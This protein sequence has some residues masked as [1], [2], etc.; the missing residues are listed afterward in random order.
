[1]PW[2][3]VYPREN[4]FHATSLKSNPVEIIEKSLFMSVPSVLKSAA[5]KEGMH[6]MKEGGWVERSVVME[7]VV[8]LEP[9]AH[10]GTERT[11]GTL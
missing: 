6:N 1:M 11:P 4:S 7:F 9:G 10:D 2:E 8:E 5:M 3:V